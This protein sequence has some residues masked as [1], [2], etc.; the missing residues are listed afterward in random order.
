MY[1]ADGIRDDGDDAG[2]IAERS[3]LGSGEAGGEPADGLVVGVQDLGGAAVP[4]EGSDDA[5]VPVV[6]GGEGEGFLR[7]GDVDD[8]GVLAIGGESRGEEE[9]EG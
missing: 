2:G 3:G 8:E 4:R 1:V 6:V 5:G 9:R 7:F